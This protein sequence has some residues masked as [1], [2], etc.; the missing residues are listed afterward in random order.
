MKLK[1]GTFYPATSQGFVIEAPDG[2]FTFT[3]DSRRCTTYP[4]WTEADKAGRESV[5]GL[6]E[7]RYWNVLRPAIGQYAT[8]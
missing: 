4:T 7:G 1:T 5:R 2:S 8:E 3:P 6:P